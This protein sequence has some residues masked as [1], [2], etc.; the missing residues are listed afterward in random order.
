M[1]KRVTIKPGPGR[2]VRK[3]RSLHWLRAE[4][5]PVAWSPFWQRRLMAGDVVLVA[6]APARDAAVTTSAK[7]PRKKE[8]DQ[9]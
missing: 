6:P 4:G 9:P 5:E 1:S 7:R 3:P 8:G 2:K